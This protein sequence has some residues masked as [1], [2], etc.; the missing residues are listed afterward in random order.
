[1]PPGWQGVSHEAGLNSLHDAF[2]PDAFLPDQATAD[3]G[4]GVWVRMLL[5][6]GWNAV[7]SGCVGR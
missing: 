3:G 4:L 5:E 1:M 2:F 6:H 7:E